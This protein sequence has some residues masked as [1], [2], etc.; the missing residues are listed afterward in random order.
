M[1]VPFISENSDQLI[2]A[3]WAYLESLTVEITI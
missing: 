1:L 3:L 2:E